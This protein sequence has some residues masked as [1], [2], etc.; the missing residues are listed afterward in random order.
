MLLE[1]AEKTIAGIMFAAICVSLASY[2]G[3]AEL[4]DPIIVVTFLAIA[5]LFRRNRDLVFVCMIFVIERGLEELVWR[6]L[7]NDIRFELPA[8]LFFV[9]V[10]YVC[11]QGA[12]R[13]FALVFFVASMAID[14]YWHFTAEWAPFTLLTCY[15]MAASIVVRY[16]LM[17]RVFW[18]IDIFDKSGTPMPLDIMLLR[19]NAC[20]IA[21]HA[22]VTVEYYARWFID[23]DIDYLYYANS[24]I[25]HGLS[26]F[27]LYM[28]VVESL[29]HLGTV[30]LNA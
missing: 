16:A 18:Q 15:M 6:T 20:F 17:R 7:Q 29:R 23:W 27:I 1:F 22:L 5:L 9:Y 25:A 28:V 14:V 8:Y 24:Y 12:L 11:A 13:W 3:H 4:F 26:V 10:S 21:L 2:F 30:E 19:A